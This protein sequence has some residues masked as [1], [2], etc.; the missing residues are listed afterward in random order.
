LETR[1][2]PLG[3]WVSPWPLRIPVVWAWSVS[4]AWSD[5]CGRGLERVEL[6]QRAEPKGSET[7]SEHSAGVDFLGTRS[8]LGRGCRLRR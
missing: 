8:R 5:V 7:S 4:E 3:C 6:A 2:P 1:S